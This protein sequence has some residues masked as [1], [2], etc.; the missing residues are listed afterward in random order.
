MSIYTEQGYDHRADYLASL[1]D[2]FG[3]ELEAVR[4]LADLLGPTEDFDGLVTELESY[5]EYLELAG[6]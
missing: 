1:A 6:E 4:M 5:A 3:L 2:E